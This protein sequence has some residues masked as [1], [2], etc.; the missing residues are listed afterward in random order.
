MSTWIK[1]TLATGAVATASTT[2]ALA[3]LGKVEGNSA[4]GPINAVSHI[5]WGDEA[6]HTDE[7]DVA[8][9][10]TGAALNAAAI[11]MWAALHELLMPRDRKPTVARAVS[12]G[13][14]VATVAYVVDYHVVPK[15]LTPGFEKRLSG[16]AL[17][18]I[19]ATLAASLAV[20]SLL[21]ER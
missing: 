4:V 17:A 21:R 12:S 15:R 3:V 16:T 13:L 6:A 5:L 7:P 14:L 19:Y 11:T 10:L 18:S 9:T 20:G 1:D 2:A 8:H